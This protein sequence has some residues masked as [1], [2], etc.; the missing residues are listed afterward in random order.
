MNTREYLRA[1]RANH[2]MKSQQVDEFS[3]TR[4]NYSQCMMNEFS[5]SA[6]ENPIS[7]RDVSIQYSNSLASNSKH[8]KSASDVPSDENRRTSSSIDSNE[9]SG[10]ASFLNDASKSVNVDSNCNTIKS[11]P[12]NSEDDV[13]YDL[14]YSLDSPTTDEVLGKQLNDDIESSSWASISVESSS[15]PLDNDKI[16][17]RKIDFIKIPHNRSVANCIQTGKKFIA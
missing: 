5:F 17:V 4:E 1:S 7:K 9:N 11:S 2:T 3:H 14:R 12:S 16:R 10:S 15:V 6:E 8:N 13:N